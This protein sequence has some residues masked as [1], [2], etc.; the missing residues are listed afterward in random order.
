MVFV[1]SGTR[2]VCLRRSL[3]VDRIYGFPGVL[4]EVDQI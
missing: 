2:V 1:E 4:A 3:M